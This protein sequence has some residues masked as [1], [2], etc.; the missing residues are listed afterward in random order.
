MVAWL[1]VFDEL[2]YFMQIFRDEDTTLG[3]TDGKHDN[4]YG[5]NDPANPIIRSYNVVKYAPKT[6]VEFPSI[7]IVIDD[8]RSLQEMGEAT[9]FGEEME[10]EL[11]IYLIMLESETIQ[12]NGVTYHNENINS[13][14]PNENDAMMLLRAFVFQRLEDFRSYADANIEWEIQDWTGTEAI[15]GL[16]GVED[17]IALRLRFDVVFQK[18]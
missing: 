12:Y 18:V 6:I 4:Y 3:L 16:N 15:T 1:D 10:A 2:Y 13:P 7:Q 5:F 17:L 14:H 9:A 11:S 8:E